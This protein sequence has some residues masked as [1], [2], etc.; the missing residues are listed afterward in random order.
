MSRWSVQ[1]FIL[2][3]IDISTFTGHSTRAA[4]TSKAKA[5]GV[6]RREKL[7]R[8]YWSKTSTFQKY[9]K[10]RKN[11]MTVCDKL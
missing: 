1:V 11:R 10:K 2:A 6:L 8:G 7:K 9:Y 4:T 5:L 3:G